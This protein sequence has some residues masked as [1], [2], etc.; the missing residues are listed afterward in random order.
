MRCVAAAV[1]DPF[2]VPVAGLSISGPSFR[3]QENAVQEVGALVKKS[4]KDLTIA[5]GGTSKD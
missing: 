5:I 1:F 3:V 2:G 4:A